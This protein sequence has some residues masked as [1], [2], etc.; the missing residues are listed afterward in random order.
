MKDHSNEQRGPG[1][2]R[3]FD[4]QAAVDEAL[5]VFRERG[6]HAASIGD[7]AGAMKLT[8]GSIYKAFSDKRAIFLAALERYLDMRRTQLH[9]RLAAESSGLDKLR[10]TLRFYAETSHDLEGRRGCLIAGSAMQIGVLDAELA[11]RVA[12]ALH[13]IET[14]L[15]DLIRLGQADG[16]IPA[17]I[18]PK[19]SARALLCMLQGLR[20]VGKT[21][22]SRDDMVSA[23]EQALRILA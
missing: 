9:Q 19:A 4:L 6:Y 13:Q 1:R 17:K 5:V 14:M 18:D 23:A 10:A 15:L 2:P 22:P 20:V 8:T 7:L 12:G 11:S 21:G 16:S 3:E